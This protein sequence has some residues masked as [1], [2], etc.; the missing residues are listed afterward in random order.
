MKTSKIS[1]FFVRRF[2]TN[3]NLIMI[4]L[5]DEGGCVESTIITC[6]QA[7]QLSEQLLKVLSGDMHDGP[8]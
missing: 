6:D 7:N 2:I 8:A 3:R 5:W 4:G 1:K